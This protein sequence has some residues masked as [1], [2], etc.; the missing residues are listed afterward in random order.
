MTIND[1]K[2]RSIAMKIKRARQNAHMTQA[3]VADAL[4][5][6]YQAI[7]NYERG[8]NNIENTI[9]VR[10]CSLYG[11]QTDDILRDEETE[12]APA[13]SKSRERVSDEDIKF[14]LFGG[15][16]EI[17]DE[18]YEEVLRFAAY[19]KERQKKG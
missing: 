17:T 6:T 3:Q 13:G 4:G 2:R 5:L 14:A 8:L 12:E 15:D 18:M 10:M 7:S 16:G 1:L 19:V 11:V 9:L